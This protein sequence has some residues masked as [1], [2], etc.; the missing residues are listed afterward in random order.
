MA[1]NRRPTVEE[2]VS[3][4]RRLLTVVLVAGG[5][6]LLS[7]L[8]FKLFQYLLHHLVGVSIVAAVAVIVVSTITLFFLISSSGSSS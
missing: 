8:A 3:L 7:Y 4:G 1:P 5:V 2:S 6:I